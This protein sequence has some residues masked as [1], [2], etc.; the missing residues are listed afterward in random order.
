MRLSIRMPIVRKG[1]SNLVARLGRKVAR[2][3]ELCIILQGFVGGHRIGCHCMPVVPA[4]TL[5]KTLYRYD[6][7]GCPGPYVVVAHTVMACIAIDHIVM[8]PR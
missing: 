4:C 1:P 7:E 5:G 6:F 3:V 8:V 2:Q